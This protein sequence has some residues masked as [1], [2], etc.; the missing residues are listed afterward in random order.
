M[1]LEFRL[2]L[3]QWIEEG[4]DVIKS[5]LNSVLKLVSLGL[6]QLYEWL[7][8]A[9]TALPNWATA[10]LIV[11]CCFVVRGRAN[12][13]LVSGWKFALGAAVGLTLIIAL[14]QWDDA[15]K[16]LSLVL[17]A[18]LIAL[19]MAIP[20]GIW[21]AKSPTA[22]AIIRPIM[23]FFQT[24]PAMVYLI[25]AIIFFSVG[26]VP[27]I[28][29]TVI[30]SMPPGVRMTTLGIHGV[31]KEVVEA[32]RAFG[33]TPRRTLRQVE[34]PLAMPSI[35]AGVNQ[36]IMLAL[37]M[38]VIA[39]MVGA[40]GLGREVYLALGNGDVARGFEA[41]I[42]VVILAMLLDRLSGSFASTRQRRRRTV[43]AADSTEDKSATPVADEVAKAEQAQP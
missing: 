1:D 18:S 40:E 43:V 39:G 28:V 14:D 36:V 31:D 42:A 34:L 22:A 37:S 5:S 17:V 6:E 20:L 12:G 10:L 19:V 7:V 16:S 21:A 15:M 9:F 32:S 3:G 23:D 8:I 4:V 29:A 30:F 24:M 33:A 2:P 38:V 25:P 27:G 41:G 26:T 35:M 11:L 13:K